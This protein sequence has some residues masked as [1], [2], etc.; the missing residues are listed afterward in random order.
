LWSGKKLLSPYHQMKKPA[1]KVPNGWWDKK[2]TK[3]GGTHWELTGRGGGEKG[4]PPP[5]YKGGD[6]RPK[7]RGNRG[8]S[9]IHK[10]RV[11]RSKDCRRGRGSRNLGGGG[12]TP[13]GGI[14]RLETGPPET[15]ITIKPTLKGGL[16]RRV[17]PYPII[18]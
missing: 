4:S 13:L 10:K 15:K 17:T 6:W 18:F 2:L 16:P 8:D 3:G 5:S 7:R 14:P 11:L 9:L 1:M 12:S